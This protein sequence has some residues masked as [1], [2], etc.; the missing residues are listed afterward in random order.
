MRYMRYMTWNN[1]GG[2]GKTFLTYCM[3]VE[4]A[5]AN[6]DKIVGVVDLCPQSNI[7]EILLGGDGDGEERLNAL[8]DND[9]TIASYI[10]SRYDS[11]RF[12]KIG[13]EVNFFVKVEEYNHHMPGNLYLLPGDTDLDVCSLLIEYLAGAPEKNAWFKSRSLLLDLVSTFEASK[14]E[15]VV[16]FIDSNPSF[17]NY[18]Q[19]GITVADRIIVP[20][21]ADS[22]SIRGIYNLFRLVF[23]VK[24]ENR[25]SE[26]IF[27]TF[28][29]KMKEAGKNFP[30]VHSFVLNKARVQKKEATVAYKSHVKQIQDVAAKLH[31]QHPELF[32]TDKKS[33]GKV[34]DLKDGNNLAVVLNNCGLPPSSLTHKKYVV[35]GE[36]TQVNQSQ[37][38]PFIEDLNAVVADL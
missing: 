1:K 25:L 31:K 28:F 23:G 38:D 8:Y 24:T 7:S 5:K 35:Y 13:N 15:N 9:R 16:I 6:P 11:S 2:V 19:L 21:T 22:A 29:A 27:D 18:T 20:C 33:A 14:K 12:G 36:E 32:T 37:I 30:Q 4:Y 17:A 26:D 34:F 10:K 3:A